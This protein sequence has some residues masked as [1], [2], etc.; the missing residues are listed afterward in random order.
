MKR[1]SELPNRPKPPEGHRP[2]AEAN[3]RGMFNFG[4]IQ[5]MGLG[6]GGL[7][8]TFN[9]GGGQ[10]GG[11]R[12]NFNWFSLGI[13]IVMLLFSIFGEMLVMVGPGV[14]RLERIG[15]SFNGQSRAQRNN[16]VREVRRI[17]PSWS[18]LLWDNLQ[19]FILLGFLALGFYVHRTQRRI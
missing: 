2:N 17:E 5:F 13:C 19:I 14:D 15:P 8:F 4:N 10:D 12:V 1:T 3:N 7:G 11:A 18:E 16:R 9:L 6:F